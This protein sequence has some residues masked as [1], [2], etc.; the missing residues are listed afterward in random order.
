MI[1]GLVLTGVLYPFSEILWLV[2]WLLA[3][4]L[5]FKNKERNPTLF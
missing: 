1:I 3:C 2:L 4:I 5:L